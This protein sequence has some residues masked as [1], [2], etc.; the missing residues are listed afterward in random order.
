MSDDVEINPSD[1]I[2]PAN[3]FKRVSREDHPDRCGAVGPKGQCQFYRTPNG[4]MCIKHGGTAQEKAH[5]REDLEQY[6]LG[7]YKARVADFAT[8]PKVLTLRDEIGITRMLLETKLNRWSEA[9]DLIAHSGVILQNITAIQKL[10]TDCKKLE[11]QMGMLLDRA[12]IQK[13]CDGI[14]NVMVRYLDEDQM[15]EVADLVMGEIAAATASRI[16]MDKDS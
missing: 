10:V 2:D 3:P 9:D 6:R 15:R 14:L 8:N 1:E 11:S 16:E 4:T 5:K 7:K 13:L 12:A